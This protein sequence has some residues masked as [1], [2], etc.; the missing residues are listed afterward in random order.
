V[1]QPLAKRDLTPDLFRARRL[2]PMLR[3]EIAVETDEDTANRVAG[4][5]RR[6]VGVARLEVERGRVVTVV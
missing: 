6:I 3:A 1:L 4:D 2:G 5:L